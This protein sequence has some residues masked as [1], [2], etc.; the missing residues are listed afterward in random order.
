[1]E[2][3]VLEP[4]DFDTMRVG[5]GLHAR[6]DVADLAGANGGGAQAAAGGRPISTPPR[7]ARPVLR[8]GARGPAR[9]QPLVRGLAARGGLIRSRHAGVHSIGI[10]PCAP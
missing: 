8:R 3:P 5:Y 4:T 2:E 9:L 7:S 10:A 1:M 6:L